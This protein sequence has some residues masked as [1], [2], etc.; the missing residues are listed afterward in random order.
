VS[1]LA[2]SYTAEMTLL[3]GRARR[4]WA[5][6]AIVG[7]VLLPFAVSESLALDLA[8]LCAAAIAAIGLNLVT[9]YAG[10]VS[11]G[12]AF[13]IGVG[14]YTAAVLGG[15]GSGDVL[16]Y[17]LSLLIWLPAAG[18][19]AAV[20]GLLVAPLAF[21]LRGLY[22]AIVTLGLVF[23]GQHIFRSA[24]HITGG[25]GTGRSTAIPEVGG[26]NFDEPG[27]VLGIELNRAEGLYFLALIVLIVMAVLARN[28][29]RSALGR[30]FAAVR[31]RDVAAAIMGVSIRRAK[32][33]AFVISSFF[34]GIG[35]A[36]LFLPTG[37][38]EPGSFDLLLSIQY[39]AMILIGG[40][41]TISGAI[42]GAA[43]VTL[44]PRVVEPLA[45]VIPGITTESTGGVLT[46]FQL[47]EIL[48]GLL[49]IGFLIL[50]P[51]GAFGLWTRARN[52][53]RSWPFSH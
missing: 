52:Y 23:I 33:L 21:R 8:V 53:W 42:V 24:D 38:L 5:A 2:T 34:A 9:G 15:Q 6:A 1:R 32:T 47:Q 46:T 12:H 20:A 48:Y 43:F 17:D 18:L 30:E 28:L 37:F 27:E 39:I 16:G 25:A 49:I 19:A 10:Q 7:A 11:L 22:L 26:F 44:L 35:G 51:R 14:A 40:I 50:E 41:G 31:D 3:G 29:T 4:P 36:L 13:F 45:D